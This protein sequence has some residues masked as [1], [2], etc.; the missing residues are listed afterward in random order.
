[1][2]KSN[3]WVVEWNT[4]SKEGWIPEIDGAFCSRE[5]ARECAKQCREIDSGIEYRVRKY[6]RVDR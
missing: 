2:G 5:L 3:L 6:Q 4:E 1:M